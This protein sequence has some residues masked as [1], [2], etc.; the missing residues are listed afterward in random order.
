L[1]GSRLFTKKTQ[2]KVFAISDEQAPY[3]Q[4]GAE[5]ESFFGKIAV[6][7]YKPDFPHFLSVDSPRREEFRTHS[8]FVGT[9]LFHEKKRKEGK[10]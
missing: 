1:I 3:T 9:Q 5:S 2:F 6:Y 10:L 7:G 4:S 8:I